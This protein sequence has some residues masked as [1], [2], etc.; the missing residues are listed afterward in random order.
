MPRGGERRG[1]SHPA[2]P[3]T[4]NVLNTLRLIL[5]RQLDRYRLG[6]NLGKSFHENLDFSTAPAKQLTQRPTNVI[7]GDK[8]ANST[9]FGVAIIFA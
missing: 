8:L 6:D 7:L 3:S 2:T 4:V 5:F 1:N 9:E